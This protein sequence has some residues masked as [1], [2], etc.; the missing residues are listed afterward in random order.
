MNIIGDFFL[1]LIFIVGGGFAQAENLS[2]FTGLA[3]VYH[4]KVRST[5]I[6]V[7][8]KFPIDFSGTLVNWPKQSFRYLPDEF[9]VG[10]GSIQRPFYKIDKSAGSPLHGRIQEIKNHI[11]SL[12]SHQKATSLSK[13]E[14]LNYLAKNIQSYIA[15]DRDPSHI[16][17]YDWY[18]DPDEVDLFDSKYEVERK[19]LFDTPMGQWVETD[20]KHFSIPYE[21]ILSSKKGY[22]IE[23]VLLT[24]FLLES[25]EI[26]HRVVFGSVLKNDRK[27]GGHTWI[28]LTDGRILDVSWNTVDFPKLN[29][30]PIQKDWLWFGNAKG[31]QYRYEYNFFPLVIY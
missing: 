15:W 19:K 22:C 18:A 12:H 11:I 26:P 2:A 6:S 3:H 24:S 16:R 8:I 20:H 4:Y 1:A 9:V 7:L 5:E 14:V 23:M 13:E 21:E 31:H 17:D 27:G 30:H 28:Q 10:S 25:F 29:R